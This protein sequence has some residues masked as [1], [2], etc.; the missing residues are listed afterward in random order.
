MTDFE[1][2]EALDDDSFDALRASATPVLIRE[3]QT[4]TVAL[5]APPQP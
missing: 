2:D 4:H 3:G 1:P 5:K